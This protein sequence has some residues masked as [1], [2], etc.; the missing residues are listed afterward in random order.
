[1]SSPEPIR[2]AMR[3]FKQTTE[4]LAKLL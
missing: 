1:M 3:V 2:S 4:R